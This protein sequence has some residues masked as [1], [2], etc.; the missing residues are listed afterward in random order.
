[1]N[2]QLSGFIIK[3]QENDKSLIVPELGGYVSYAPFRVVLSIVRWDIVGPSKSAE[4]VL[5]K[6]AVDELI[7]LLKKALD[8]DKVVSAWN[9]KD[10]V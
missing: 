1:M 8:T 4:V 3:S 2:P 6:S 9:V 10:D 5:D 7:H